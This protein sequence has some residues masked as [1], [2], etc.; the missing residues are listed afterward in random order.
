MDTPTSASVR[1]PFFRPDISL[2]EEAEVLAVLRSGWLTTGP[3]VRQFE[4][5][6]AHA[7][8]AQHA[9]AVNSA[10][11]ALHL[12]VEA[13]GLGR[14]FTRHAVLVPTMTFA[15]TAEVVR[16]MNAVPILV[17]C[18]PSTLN[19][20]FADAERKLAR[21]A[22]GEL[23]GI[24]VVDV[25]GII[26]VHVGGV[27]VDMARLREFSA[28]HDLWVVEDAAH[29]FPA[30]WRP[31]ADN[32]WTSCGSDTS[33]VT[34]FSFY[35]NKTITTG[36]GGMAVTADRRVADRMRLMSLHG[37]SRDAWN[38]YN[39]GGSWDYQ[40]VEPGM[41]YN[42]T[43]ICAAIGIGQL[44]RSEE[45]R[46]AR[47]R[48]AMRYS[49]QLRH[50]AEIEPP[51]WPDN[52]LHAW[53]LYPVRLRLDQLRIGRNEFIE[54]L[55][56]SDIGCSVHWRPLHLHP[57]YREQFGWMPEEFPVASR[58]WERLI[59]LPLFPSM[60]TDEQD[61]VV[62]TVAGICAANKA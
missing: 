5:Q 33:A 31:S 11:A 28:A 43:D 56:K 62:D 4:E 23:P 29:A 17:D 26:P 13:L 39:S 51:P 27:M 46:E 2:A 3:R 48:L 22:R 41:K 59:S 61:F 9:V 14:G 7:V 35:A 42:L 57:Y 21:A 52:R 24:G 16:Y 34:C 8:G 32:E 25:V 58:E 40:I 37:L 20:D 55:K 12:A 53:H 45:M 15:A 6:F 36:E 19:I 18:D 1:V 44:Q 49:T 10:T 54:K 30:A 38:R 50:L 47:E 60:T